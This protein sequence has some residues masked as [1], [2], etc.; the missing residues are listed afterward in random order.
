MPHNSRELRRLERK[1][2]R[3]GSWHHDTYELPTEMDRALDLYLSI[4]ANNWKSS[5]GQGV[6][7]SPRTKELYQDLLR[8]LFPE[9]RVTV[10]FPTQ[11]AEHLSAEISTRLGGGERPTESKRL[12][13][14]ATRDSLPAH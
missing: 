12:T 14:C 4:E 11:G 5:E 3:S 6:G 13:P 10:S 7:K 2:T 9:G 1:L 8:R